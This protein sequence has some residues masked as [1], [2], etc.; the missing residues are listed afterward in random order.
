VA[1]AVVVGYTFSLRR[2]IKKDDRALE[3]RRRRAERKCGV[4]SFSSTLRGGG[5]VYPLLNP[6]RIIARLY[7]VYIYV[8][9]IANAAPANHDSSEIA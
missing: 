3:R 1:A 8:S 7:L 6:P 4:D 9:G 5:G 2:V